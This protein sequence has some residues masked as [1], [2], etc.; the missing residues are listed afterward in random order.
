MEQKDIT[1]PSWETAP[2]SLAPADLLLFA[3]VVEGGSLTRAADRMGLPKST[4]SRRL[5][6]LEQQMG[7]PLLIRTTRRQTLT[8]LGA[9]LME[10]ARE[11]ASNRL[12]RSLGIDTRKQPL[13]SARRCSRKAITASR[14]LANSRACSIN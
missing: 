14:L 4:V 8:E 9:Q 5:A 11:L 10:H 2:A 12:A 13:G 6:A 3:Q 1:L 7:E